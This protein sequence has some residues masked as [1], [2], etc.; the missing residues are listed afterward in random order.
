M[1]FPIEQSR[2]E[3]VYVSYLWLVIDAQHANNERWRLDVHEGPAHQQTMG[4]IRYNT[5]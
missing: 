5:Q 1:P 2:A 3:H 4:N